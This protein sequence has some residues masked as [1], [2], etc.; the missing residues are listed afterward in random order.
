MKS[1]QQ[2]T[3]VLSVQ[4]IDARRRRDA[5]RER[6]MLMKQRRNVKQTEQRSFAEVL[7][8]AMTE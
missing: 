7:A 4:L 8:S 3:A 2:I 6:T 1:V 5:D